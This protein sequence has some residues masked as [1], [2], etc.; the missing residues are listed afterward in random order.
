MVISSPTAKKT[1][2]LDLE[3]NFSEQEMLAKEEGVGKRR[4]WFRTDLARWPGH[5][6]LARVDTVHDQLATSSD[7]MDGILQDLDAPRRLNN[8]VETIGILGLD[9]LKH[10][11]RVR[12]AQCHVLISGI[13]AL[14]QIDLETLGSSN[15]DLTAAVLTQHL[16]EDEASGTGAE[17]EDRGTHFGGDFVETVGGAG[18]GLEEGGVDVGEVLDG[19]DAASYAE[20]KRYVR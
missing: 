20:R 8:N 2:L 1:I 13:E 18:G 15:D 6:I 4:G 10:G 14:G 16:G 5:T 17:H 3:I 12:S 11:L 9:L 19:E 7:I